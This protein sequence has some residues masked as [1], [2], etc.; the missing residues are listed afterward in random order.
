MLPRD[1]Y[2]PGERTDYYVTK[3]DPKYFVKYYRD[4]LTAST[5][6]SP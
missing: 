5:Q 1:Y 4:E 2:N 3:L 6:C